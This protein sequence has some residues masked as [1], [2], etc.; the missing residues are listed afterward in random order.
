GVAKLDVLLGAVHKRIALVRAALFDELPALAAFAAEIDERGAI[1]HDAGE[2]I[3]IVSEAG[4]VADEEALGVL[5][6]RL[7][8]V[9]I[10]AAVLP[11]VDATLRD[12]GNGEVI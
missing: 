12:G 3:A 6:E 5:E 10:L 11:A 9:G 2:A 7:E 4:G 1:A 8:G